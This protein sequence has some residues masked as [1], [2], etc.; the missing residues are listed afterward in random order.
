MNEPA[1]YYIQACGAV[2]IALRR[3]NDEWKLFHWLRGQVINHINQA[4]SDAKRRLGSMNIYAVLAFT[5]NEAFGGDRRSASE[6]HLPALRKMLAMKGGEQA[7]AMEFP[8]PVMMYVRFASQYLTEL[9]GVE[10]ILTPVGVEGDMM[11]FLAQ[12]LNT[13]SLSKQLAHEAERDSRITEAGDDYTICNQ[14]IFD[15]R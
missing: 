11:K 6:V 7:F 4:L 14:L 12:G 2:F 15:T 1:I 5:V 3:G 10:P 13:G 8:A 9:L